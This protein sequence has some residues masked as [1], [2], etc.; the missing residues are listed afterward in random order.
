MIKIKSEVNC[1]LSARA[2]LTDSGLELR[3]SV[4]TVYDEET[5]AVTTVELTVPEAERNLVGGALV[6]ALQACVDQ[7]PA[8]IQDAI[9]TS[10]RV[11]LA[12]KEIKS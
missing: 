3:V 4:S 5:R 9:A 10:R 12:N 11:A 2:T 1:W 6:K 8:K 7:V